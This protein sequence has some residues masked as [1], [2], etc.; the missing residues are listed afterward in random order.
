MTM[1]VYT[2]LT[3]DGMD[4]SIV[5]TDKGYIDSIKDQTIG[6]EDSRRLPIY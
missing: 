2:F 4:K 3:K 5:N 1:Y 6:Q